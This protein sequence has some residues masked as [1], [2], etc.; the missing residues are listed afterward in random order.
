[1]TWF[2]TSLSEDQLEVI[3]LVKN[4][5]PEVPALDGLEDEGADDRDAARSALI[6]SGAWSIGI[7]ETIGGGGAPLALR[8]TALIAIG[9]D[10]AAL[11]WAIVQTHAAAEA[12]AS[13]ATHGEL[14]KAVVA[15]EQAICVVDADSDAVRLELSGDRA[16]GVLKRLDPAGE[17]PTVL[18]LDGSDAAWVIPHDALREPRALRRTG[19]A[20]AGSFSA[21]IDAT[22]AA[23]ARIAG[24]D[25]EKVRSSLQVGAAAIA[26]G[27]AVSAAEAA[28]AYSAERVQFGGP[29]TKLLTVR[30]AL[31]RQ[32]AEAAGAIADSLVNDIPTPARSA[33][34][35]EAACEVAI[36]VTASAVQSHGGYGYLSEYG[37]ERRVRDA[38]SLR[39]ASGAASAVRRISAGLPPA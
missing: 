30:T 4:I 39:A 14:L 2:D 8:Q 11:A 21:T 15:G 31:S 35:L 27:L 20:G 12:L 3:E 17:R 16:R 34:V 37:I 19:F 25:I 26:A 5:L 36:A 10:Q 22:P 32:A 28:A 29:L 1:M 23:D 33:A 18:V 7:D 38:V 24:V 6:D 13:S 9:A